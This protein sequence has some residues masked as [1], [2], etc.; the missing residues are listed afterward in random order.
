MTTAMTRTDSCSLCNVWF[1]F[2]WRNG[3]RDIPIESVGTATGEQSISRLEILSA[4]V[5]S[6]SD[7]DDEYAHCS[8]FSHCMTSKNPLFIVLEGGGWAREGLRYIPT[9]NHNHRH[10]Q[11]HLPWREAAQRFSFTGSGRPA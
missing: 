5:A 3:G 4:E 10:I 9:S 6:H 2:A 8:L 7:D 11:L 1:L